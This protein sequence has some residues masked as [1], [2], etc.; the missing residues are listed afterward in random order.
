MPRYTYECK[1]CGNVFLSM[2]S[3]SER[4]TDCEK[5][6][7]KDTLKRVI[8]TISSYSKKENRDGP[9]K[10]GAL[11][12]SKISEFKEDLKKEKKKLRESDY[13]SD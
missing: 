6:G 2:H 12:D 10:A 5:C 13:E 3:F 7:G 8:P 11:V 4:L 9:K 1:A